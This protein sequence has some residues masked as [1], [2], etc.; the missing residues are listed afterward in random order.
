MKGM[1]KRGGNA[2]AAGRQ[3]GAWR[4]EAPRKSRQHHHIRCR[5][6]HSA[7]GPGMPV[8][9][10][11]PSLRAVQFRRCPKDPADHADP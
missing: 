4:A 5:G 7:L 6:N 8:Q 2:G 1:R 3:S 11:L 10:V 9:V